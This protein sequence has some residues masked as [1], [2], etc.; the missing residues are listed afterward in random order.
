MFSTVDL[1]GPMDFLEPLRGRITSDMGEDLSQ[2]FTLKEVFSALQQLHP[3]KALGLD[4]MSPL[5]YQ[6]YKHI[7][8]S[9]IIDV[10]V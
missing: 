1:D 4:D 2:L 7:V 3:M 9:S 5:F 8:G 6:K 10:V